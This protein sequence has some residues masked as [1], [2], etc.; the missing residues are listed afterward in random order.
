ML[1]Q[2]AAR[3]ETNLRS[4]ASSE[5][6]RT[7]IEEDDEDS[8]DMPISYMADRATRPHQ[9][10]DRAERD[11]VDSDTPWL[12]MGRRGRRGGGHAGTL[13]K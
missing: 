8:D 4:I 10:K 5:R 11:S 7:E 1:E 12:L 3:I 13:S 9:R 6:S 2:E